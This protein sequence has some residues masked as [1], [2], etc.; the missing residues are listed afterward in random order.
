MAPRDRVPLVGITE[1][2]IA[3]PTDAQLCPSPE[4]LDRP[5]DLRITTTGGLSLSPAFGPTARFVVAGQFGGEPE[6]RVLT[7]S[8][9]LDHCP[10]GLLGVPFEEEGDVSRVANS[11]TVYP[12]GGRPAARLLLRGP[13]YTVGWCF[14]ISRFWRLN[15]VRYRCALRRTV[16]VHHRNDLGVFSP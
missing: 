11:R 5:S 10:R 16:L 1:T 12:V 4:L 3:D 7:A 6:V 14:L 8:P 2:E 9:R 15:A 13:M